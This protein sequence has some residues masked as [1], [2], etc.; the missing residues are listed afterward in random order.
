MP[1]VNPL[2]TSFDGSA[3]VFSPGIESLMDQQIAPGALTAGS[4]A[5]MNV[6]AI[7]GSTVN[8]A[9]SSEN[10]AL[11]VALFVITGLVGVYGLNKLGFRAM[12]AVGKGG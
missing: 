8:A 11:H 7:S 3:Q 12:V 6:G 10:V 5:Q 2:I 9:G 4:E 1:S